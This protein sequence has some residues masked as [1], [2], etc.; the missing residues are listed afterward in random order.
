MN[1]SKIRKQKGE[2]EYE[3][4]TNHIVDV[5][6]RRVVITGMGNHIVNASI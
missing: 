3:S 2:K 4:K 1:S 5:M 6:T